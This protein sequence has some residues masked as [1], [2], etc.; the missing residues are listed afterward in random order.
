MQQKEKGSGGG[1]NRERS[2]GF[3]TMSFGLV[4]YHNSQLNTTKH[5][6]LKKS[7]LFREGPQDTAQSRNKSILQTLL[8]IDLVKK[9]EE[10]PIIYHDFKT[11]NILLDVNFNAKL[12]NFGLAKDSLLGD[13]THLSTQVMGTYGYPAPEYVMTGHLTAFF[14]FWRNFQY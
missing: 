12:S 13:Q 5:C 6:Y 8:N 10:K 11:S 3:K 2:N 4:P 14:P 9:N 7:S 1:K